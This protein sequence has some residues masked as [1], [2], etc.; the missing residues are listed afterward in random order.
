MFGSGY[1][2]SSD[3]Y[4]LL[5]LMLMPVIWEEKSKRKFSVCEWVQKKIVVNRWF[6]LVYQYMSFQNSLSVFFIRFL[7]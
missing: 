5:N 7:G 2:Y 3:T 4:R 1:I 6:S